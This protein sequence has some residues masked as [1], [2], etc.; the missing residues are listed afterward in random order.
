MTSTHRRRRRALALVALLGALT[1]W[2]AI[3]SAAADTATEAAAPPQGGAVEV[4]YS[5]VTEIRPGEGWLIDCSGV[6]D[7][8]GI[9]VSCADESVTLVSAG[10]DTE[11]GE[12]TLT[13]PQV[14]GSTTISVAYR[15]RLELPPIPEIALGRLDLPIVVGEQTLVPLSAL[16]ITCAVCTTDGGASI[17]VDTLPAGVSAGVSETHLALR[18]ENAGDAIVPLTITDDAGQAVSVELTVTFVTAPAPTLGALHV[19]GDAEKLDIVDLIWGGDATVVCSSPQSIGLRCTE[20]GA[21]ERTGKG[22]AQLFF[23][24]V[25]DDGRLTWGSITDD[26]DADVTELVAPSWESEAPLSLV[27]APVDEQQADDAVPLAGLARL[28]EGIPAS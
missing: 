4:S 9:Q 6:G 19:T 27:S 7:L 3:S 15:I 18:G 14:S 28:L 13:V 5:D 22:P 20:D 11:L 24:A 2:P 21:V 1:V 25:D 12:Q 10:F 16:G 23:R 8:D 26:A 17:R